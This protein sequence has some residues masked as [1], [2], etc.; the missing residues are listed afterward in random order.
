MRRMYVKGYTDE[1]PNGGKTVYAAGVYNLQDELAEVM[2]E[3]GV[4]FE[5]DSDDRPIFP[6]APEQAAAAPAVAVAPGSKP[7]KPAPDVPAVAVAP[8]PKPEPELELEDISADDQDEE[9]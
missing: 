7:D 9:D 3:A 6:L 8:T 5:V 4:A 1:L 2:A